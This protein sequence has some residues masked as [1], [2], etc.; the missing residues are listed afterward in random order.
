ML[1][2]EVERLI[3]AVLA[4]SEP[5]EQGLAAPGI[6]RFAGRGHAQR[7]LDQRLLHAARQREGRMGGEH[8]AKARP[9]DALPELLEGDRL[10]GARR[11]G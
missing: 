4:P 5:V 11:R 1:L 10:R 8:H 6:E 3:G 9:L 2:V 7:Q